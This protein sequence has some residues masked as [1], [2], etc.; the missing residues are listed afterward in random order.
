MSLCSDCG[1]LIM[2]TLML[3]G[4]GGWWS[5]DLHLLGFGPRLQENC[6]FLAELEQWN[7]DQWNRPYKLFHMDCIR[8][9]NWARMAARKL[10]MICDISHNATFIYFENGQKWNFPVRNTQ[11][12]F[13]DGHFFLRVGFVD[14]N[15][16]SWLVITKY[17]LQWNLYLIDH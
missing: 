14:R 1:V 10:C 12:H 15:K 16:S 5:W 8:T 17:L 7:K 3:M 11:I 4:R 2:E 9:H 13:S 6:S